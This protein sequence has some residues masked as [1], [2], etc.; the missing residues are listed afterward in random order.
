MA[1]SRSSFEIAGAVAKAASLVGESEERPR[2]FEG[3]ALVSFGAATP[4]P[5]PAVGGERIPTP[6]PPPPISVRAVTTSDAAPDSV[7]P[8]RPP[9]L[10]DLSAVVSPVVRCQKIVEWIG[11]ATGAAD[12]FLADGSGLPIAGAVEDA[13]AR[14]AGAGLVAASIAQLAASLP[15]NGAP[16]FELHLGDGPFFQ[17]VGF[18]AQ[19]A[20][21][22]VGLNRATPLNPRQ[23]HAI[24]LACRHALGDMLGGES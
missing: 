11:E 13:E 8:R 12:V 10:P 16:L 6:T 20:V 18:E 24:R 1:R 19:G 4:A 7:D 9:K 2:L 5:P 23:A 22:L 21:Y 17:L 15:G 14:L 3:V